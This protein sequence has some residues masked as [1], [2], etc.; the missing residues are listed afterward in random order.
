MA[1]GTEVRVEAAEVQRLLGS[2]T[3]ALNPLSLEEFLAGP[4]DTYL[5]ER[6]SSRFGKGGDDAVGGKWEPLAPY[7][8]RDRSKKGFPEGPPNFRSGGLHDWIVSAPANTEIDAEGASLQ[9]PGDGGGE[10]E[11]KLHTAQHGKDPNPWPGFNPVPARPVVGLAT[12]DDVAI[13]ALFGVWLET[14]LNSSFFDGL[15]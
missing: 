15:A 1:G 9:F 3:Q 2:F 11:D 12:T 13:V 10:H 14:S 8:E 6:A 4:V 7:T 5:K